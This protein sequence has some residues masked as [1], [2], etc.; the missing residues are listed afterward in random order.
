MNTTRLRQ[1]LSILLLIIGFWGCTDHR[2][3]VVTPGASRLRVKTI[4][5]EGPNGT[6]KISAFN[7]DSQGRLSLIIGYQAPDSS[8]TPVENTV[9]QYDGQNRLTQALHS[10]VRR[11]S[12]SETYTLAY[13]A[14][15]QLSGIGNSPS[16]FGVGLQYNTPNQ[17][18]YNKG[19][20]VGGLQSSGG[21]SFTFTG[22]NLTSSTDVFSIIRLG[23]PNIPVYNRSISTTYAFDEKINPFYGAFVIP[24]PGVFLPPAGVGSFGPFY[25]YYG[26]IDNQFNFSQNNV[27]SA[28][29]GGG[30]TLYSYLY[31]AANLPTKRV[32][33][34][35]N[36]VVETLYFE[37]ENY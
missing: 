21:G 15:G 34:T 6:S 30:V 35:G 12:R 10:E 1:G 13:N 9:F 19:I 32:T 29:T 16:T 14:A 24:A 22:N 26:G 28:I 7:Y 5:Q 36:S 18:T 11:G 4:T 31:N 33:A 27:A 8:T 2:I 20:N 17:I 25:T 37:Y 3:P 23:G